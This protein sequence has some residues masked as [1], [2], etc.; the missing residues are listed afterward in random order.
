MCPTFLIQSQLFFKQRIQ[1]AH[2]FVFVYV[3]V[4]GGTLMPVPGCVPMGGDACMGENKCVWGIC[5]HLSV[6][7]HM[8]WCLFSHLQMCVWRQ[9]GALLHIPVYRHSSEGIRH[10][11][12]G[13]FTWIC[14]CWLNAHV[15]VLFVV[16]TQ[17]AG[18]E[19]WVQVCNSKL[20]CLLLPDPS[21]HLHHFFCI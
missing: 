6:N 9:L 15:C 4:Q 13:T 18:V 21:V 1:T 11:C 8:C 16:Y 12:I 7:M 3:F 10:V 2:S 14:L 19:V 17:H 5:V 20:S